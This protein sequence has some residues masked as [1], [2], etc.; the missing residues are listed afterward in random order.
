MRRQVFVL[1]VVMIARR[2]I[3]GQIEN[4]SLFSNGYSRDEENNNNNNKNTSDIKNTA[5]HKYESSEKRERERG[6]VR[7]VSRKVETKI[8]HENDVQ[9]LRRVKFVSALVQL[10]VGRRRNSNRKAPGHVNKHS[11]P[12]PTSLHGRH[13]F[14]I[15]IVDIGVA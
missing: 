12:H 3:V 4:D 2:V 5:L 9:R 15:V 6:H 7:A 13:L 11:T 14:V 10:T 8:E 1:R